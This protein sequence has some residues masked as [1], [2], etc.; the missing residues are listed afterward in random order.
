MNLSAHEEGKI[1]VVS[2]DEP[3]IDAAN[4]IQFKESFRQLMTDGRERVVLNLDGVNFVDSSGLGAIVGLMKFLAPETK[5]DLSCLCETV[6]KVFTLTRM[7]QVFRIH[8][9]L[10]D[11]IC[12][13]PA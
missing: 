9:R 7:D 12:D 4:C 13:Q 8:E 3:R 1:L 5:L 6:N 11:A 10:A 2:V